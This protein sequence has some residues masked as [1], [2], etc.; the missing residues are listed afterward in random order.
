M[1]FNAATSEDSESWSALCVSGSYFRKIKDKDKEDCGKWRL[2]P[3]TGEVQAHTPL[4][5]SD[6]LHSLAVPLKTSRPASPGLSD[7]RAPRMLS[8]PEVPHPQFQLFDYMY[9]YTRAVRVP[10]PASN[11]KSL[12]ISSQIT[13]LYILF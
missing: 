5:K 12:F 4:T 7:P 10:Q 13:K 2:D 8:R 1:D 9:R 6:H 11:A 3:W